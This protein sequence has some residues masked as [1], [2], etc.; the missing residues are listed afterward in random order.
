M[1]RMP[2]PE[3]REVC[4]ALNTRA[5][6]GEYKVLINASRTTNECPFSADNVFHNV[7][8]SHIP[9]ITFDH[10][11]SS[12]TPHR[13]FLS[14]PSS[15]STMTYPNQIYSAFSFIGFIFCVIPL[16][17]HLEGKLSRS[18]P[19]VTILTR[20]IRPQL[21]TLVLACT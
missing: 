9:L 14:P 19:T 1:P 8:F 5:L 15:T 18:T 7:Y 16:Y 21:G 17:W 20:P 13:S 12:L 11:I 6:G 4:R 2:R 3:E 10:P